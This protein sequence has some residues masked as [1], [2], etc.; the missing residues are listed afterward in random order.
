MQGND[1][2]NERNNAALAL[3]DLIPDPVVIIDAERKIV[4]A[5]RNFGKYAGC[6]SE[7]F[8]G[9]NFLELSFF[10]KRERSILQ[11]NLKKRLDG[12]VVPAYE[13]KIKTENGDSK[14]LE[15]QGNKIEYE[16]RICDLVIFHDVTERSNHQKKLRQKLL[17]SEEKFSGITNSIRDAIILV[18]K[19]AKVTYWNPA[20]EKT[21][22]YTSEET[23]G[24]YLHELVVPKAMCKEGKERIDASVKI[25]G[26]T[27]MGYF[28]VGN[29]EVIGCR[30][31]GSEF[32]AQLTVSPIKLGG[33]WNAVGVVKDITQRKREEQKLGEAEQRYHALFNQAPLGILIIDPE[34]TA[35]VEFNDVAHTQLGYT[36]E[37]F[38]KLT[39]HDITA[40]EDKDLVRR[41]MVEILRNGGGEFETKHRTKNGNIR[42]TLINALTIQLAGKTF[43][44]GVFHDITEMRT[45]QDELMKSETQY[46]QLVEHAQE[47]IW[48]LNDDMTTLFVNPRITQM[49]GYTQSEMVGKSLFEFV[50][51]GETEEAKKFL[52]QF[53]RGVD[54]AFEYAFPR[55][56][57]TYVNTS[58]AAST[59]TD[60]NGQLIGTLALVADITERK[61]M[62]DALNQER[63]MLENMAASMDAGLTLI[64]RDFHVLWANQLLKQVTGGELENKL[65]Y[66]IYDQSNRICPDCGVRKVFE[67]GV[68]VDRHDYNFKFN[69]RDEWVELIVTPVKDKDGKVVAALELAVNITERK[70]LQNKIADYSQ[71]LEELVQKRTEQLKQTQAELVKSER[72]AAIGELAGMVGHDLRNP[73]S[74]IKNS[75]YFL[76]K[77]G[78]GISPDQAKEML[79]I[80]EKCVDYSNKIVN[81]LLDYS[82]DILLDLQEFSPKQLMHES[83]AMIQVPENVKIVNNLLSDQKLKADADKIKRVFVNLIKNAID[84]MPNGGKLTI[85]GEARGNFEITFTDT[86]IGISDEVLPKLFS[87]LFTT[88]AKGM[89]FGLAICKRIVEAHGGTIVV[90]TVKNQGTAFT[91]TLPFEPTFETG[92]EKIWV[93]MPESSLSTTTKT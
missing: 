42:N 2:S 89:G 20:A 87:P 14:F 75:A 58:I 22:G 54:G 53:K 21:F 51:K 3:M 44:H 38:K 79:E 76:K 17:K 35:F 11:K 12:S 52:A 10:G 77:K 18:D 29:I 46:R 63:E 60:D 33:K 36:R 49:L 15:L 50:K 37:E 78:S 19:E 13:V 27:G 73:L 82:R 66:S 72:L 59:I 67:N 6:T 92:G 55:K 1:K 88:K 74:G 41:R 30:K 69:G 8:V 26:Q 28:T 24:K 39:I 56:D 31:D 68:P 91:V 16:G 84:A 34:T 57:G 71:R 25:F 32:P 65:C 90:K 83:L 47:G 9:E 85:D 93:N 7:E 40:E 62:Q 86:G 64:G 80:I 5:N 43:V 4:A 61:K 23:T 70:R 45:M 81:D 48:A